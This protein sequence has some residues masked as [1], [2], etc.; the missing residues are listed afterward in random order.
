MGLQTKQAQKRFSDYIPYAG[1]IGGDTEGIGITKDGLLVRTFHFTVRD[2]S[3]ATDAE[4]LSVFQNLN[5]SFRFFSEGHWWIYIDAFRSKTPLEY[6]LF[7]PDAPRAAVEFDELHK[8]ALGEFFLTD[9]FITFCYNAY[10]EK[11]LS[12]I[13]FADGQKQKD[14]GLSAATKEFIYTTDDVFNMHTNVF[15]TI[16]KLNNDETM[17]FYHRC[18]SPKYHPV[19][20]PENQ[21]FLDYYLSDA[22]FEP[23]TITRLDDTY[24]KTIAIHDFP[25][26]TR[27]DMVSKLMSAN[28]EFRFSVRFSF[29]SKDEA[30]GKIKKIRNAHF[31]KRKGIG[32]LLSEAV[33]KE[34]SVMEDTEALSYTADASEALSL[35]ASGNLFFGHLTTTL[36][37]MDESYPSAQKKTQLLKKIINESGYIAKEETFNNP[38]AFLGTFH[39]NNHNHRAPLLSTANLSH[40]FPL[41]EPW[42]GFPY[43]EHLEQITGIKQPLM[44]ARAGNSLFYLNLNVQ[45]VGHTL[46]LGPTGSGKSFALNV[47]CLQ[48]FRYK[49]AKI[50]FFDKDRSSQ[51]ACSNAGGKFIDLGSDEAKFKLNPFYQVADK[52]YRLW[53]SQFF[54]QFFTDKGI[55]LSPSDQNEILSTLESMENMSVENLSFETFRA[56]IQNADIRNALAVFIDGEYAKLF[57]AAEDTLTESSWVTFEMNTIMQ[58][59]DDIVRFV[60]GY[61]F[62]KLQE[63]FQGE[64]RLLVLDEAWLFLDNEYFATMLKDWLKTLRKKNVYVVLATQELADARNSN[65]FSTIVNACLTK[66]YLPNNQAGQSENRSLYLDLGLDDSDIRTLETSRPKRDYLYHSPLGKQLF[67]LCVNEKQTQ[68]IKEFIL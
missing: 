51:W 22:R 65:I 8:Q 13:V 60:L 36:V 11:G 59:G 35:L 2:L 28:I 15:K 6:S 57:C 67:E 37:V 39:G 19:K 54:V 61:L 33:T 7:R 55:P 27:P 9:Y 23:D 56:S 29:I 20:A 30:R 40:L 16:K 63:S 10:S 46:V 18:V 52:A 24:V 53:L 14:D 12:K 42:H 4:I 34:Q 43:N 62:K 31:Q 17:T 1:F 50:V 45:D 44:Y 47:F 41:T 25:E 26:T 21:F 32:A 66:I 3:F 38:L 48:Y 49:G 58:M 5:N 64:P 68:F